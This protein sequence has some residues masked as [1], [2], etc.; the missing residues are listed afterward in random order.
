MST[1]AAPQD[2]AA[3]RFEAAPP[4]FA[5]LAP[6]GEG[7]SPAGLP[8]TSRPRSFTGLAYSGD[9]IPG[10]WAW[11]ALVIDL[12]SLAL[13]TPCPCLLNHEREDPVGV[14]TL[15]V[16]DNALLASGRLLD[17]GQGADVAMAADQGFP[18]QLSIHA[19]PGVVEEIQ[20]GTAVTV[21][22]RDFSGPLTV[23]RQTRIRELSF[24]PTGYDYRTSAQ[25]LSQPATAPG[26]VTRISSTPG[27][28][29]MS[30]PSPDDLVAQ[31][32]ALSAQVADLTARAENAEAAL[33][34]SKTAAREQALLSLFADLGRPVPEASKPHYLSLSDEA[35]VALSADLKAAKPAAPAP[36]FTEQALGAPEV[37]AAA[38]SLSSIY[39][40]RR[41]N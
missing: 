23:F 39:A 21:N 27:D 5:P 38:L 14:C 30:S 25:V 29:H 12:A 16:S 1:P 15:A 9:V 37:P 20:A 11:G 35:F 31:V 33:S 36:L 24:T 40:A 34:A 22:G 17:Y 10:H 32:A 8:D 41:A 26:P 4:V 13:P 6:A 28:R 2:P 3:F 18:W 19:E 7:D